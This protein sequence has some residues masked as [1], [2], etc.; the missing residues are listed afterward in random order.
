MIEHG[1]NLS[2]LAESFT[3]KRNRNRV[4]SLQKILPPSI[5][6]QRILNFLEG[7]T[8]SVK[9]RIKEFPIILGGTEIEIRGTN[10]RDQISYTLLQQ[11]G[12]LSYLQNDGEAILDN[13]D[14]LRNGM[15][16]EQSILQKAYWDDYGIL[17]GDH[18]GLLRMNALSYKLIGEPD[19]PIDILIQKAIESDA[20][21]RVEETKREIEVTPGWLARKGL[22]E[23]NT[24]KEPKSPVKQTVNRLILSFNTAKVKKLTDSGVDPKIAEARVL[25]EALKPKEL[26]PKNIAYVERK[27]EIARETYP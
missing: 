1:P 24:P 2:A 3:R 22:P 6:S 14:I 27:L 26:T 5:D 8:V 15:M 4:E 9:R 19:G 7:D 23:K 21:K 16:G 11:F 13:S 17:L 20:T 18:L 10:L 12:N 25:A